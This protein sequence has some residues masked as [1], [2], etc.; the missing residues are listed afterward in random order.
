VYTWDNGS[1][2]E[3]IFN[4]PAGTY[5]VNITDANLCQ[6]NGSI[7]VTGPNALL[8]QGTAQDEMFGNDGSVNLTV[9]G[10]TPP[11]AYSWNNGN[12]TEDLSN[13]SA[14]TYNVNVMD[15]NGCTQTFSITVGSQVG[16]LSA[17]ASAMKLWP[18]P[19]SG[20]I[21]IEFTANIVGQLHI[22]NVAGQLIQTLP[23]NGTRVQADLSTLEDGLYFCTIADE[24]GKQYTISFTL[25][26]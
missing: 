26:R 20:N 6:I 11:Y 22:T 24:S 13:L 10:G 1:N 14:G 23:V 18:N 9:T 21:Q 19:S 3:D 12:N 16:I 2:S 5:N 4:L 17:D 7:T 25:T 8:V 15:N